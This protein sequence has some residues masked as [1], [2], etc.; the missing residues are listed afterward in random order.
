MTFDDDF[1]A[2][3]FDGGRK[4][5]TCKKLNISWPPPEELELFGFKFIRESFSQITDDMRN[6]MTR[7]CR[8]ARYVLKY[9][10]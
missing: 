7:V 10:N 6:D 8:G 5:F 4:L 9:V 1:V 3:D 2:I